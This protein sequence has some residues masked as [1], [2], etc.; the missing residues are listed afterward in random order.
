MK[1][2]H[3]VGE[4]KLNNVFTHLEIYT[5]GG[6]HDLENYFF[7]RYIIIHFLRKKVWFVVLPSGSGVMYKH[8]ILIFLNEFQR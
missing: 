4:M 6:V 5:Y 2:I 8:L 3:V 7:F 1:A